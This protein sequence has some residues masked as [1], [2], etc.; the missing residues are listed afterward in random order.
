MHFCLVFYHIL[1][2]LCLLPN[3]LLL[4]VLI[5]SGIFSCL[6]GDYLSSF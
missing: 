1:D 5:S 6:L 3:I 4:L 2:A